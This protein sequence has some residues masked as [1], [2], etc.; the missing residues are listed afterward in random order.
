M[1]V[2]VVV[3]GFPPDALGGSELYA[4]ATSLELQRRF[5]DEILV[6]TRDADPQRPEYSIR[7]AERDG[8][9]IAWV[10]NTF[11]A[12]RSFEET[13]R[14][15]A[16]T[17]AAERLI[18]AFQPDVA[19]IHHLT[20]LST[21][22]VPSLA[23]RSV[24]IVLTLHDY[25]LMCHRGQLL[26]TSYRQCDGPDS[27]CHACLGI[28]GGVGPIGFIGAG[29][30]RTIERRLPIAPGLRRS[31]ER[32]GRLLAR[33]SA[34]DSEARRRVEHMRAVCADVSQFLAPS[35]IVRDRFVAFGIDPGKIMVSPYGV[36]PAPFQT[37]P[38]ERRRPLQIGFLG[39]LMISKGPDVLLRAVARL[40]P[41]SASRHTTATIPTG[42]RSNRCCTIPMSPRTERS[43]TKRCREPSR[44][45]TSW[46][47]PRS[48]RKR[49]P[50]SSRRHS[51]PACPSSRHES[52]DLSS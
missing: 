30:V 21:T 10:N 29:I 7:R 52:A 33:D 40:P 2:L 35:Q 27:G 48:G 24:P 17:A 32:A 9:T 5:G 43:H 11:R 31:V 18:D 49:A 39:S 45:S 16:I 42:E 26:D 14:N 4:Q 28:A 25:W 23:R 13:Y 38:R 15:E 51:S 20:C 47:C 41:G 8:V 37:V 19:H 1:R 3:H 46:S 50:S 36:D 44:V 12:I 6:V 34:A 22:I